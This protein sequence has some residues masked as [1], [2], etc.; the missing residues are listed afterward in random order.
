MRLDRIR[1]GAFCTSIGALN[2]LFRGSVLGD[3]RVTLSV[4]GKP[5]SVLA[6]VKL[7]PSDLDG[8][9]QSE[10]RVQQ[11][12]LT[13]PMSECRRH[14]FDMNAAVTQSARVGTVSPTLS[15]ARA[16]LRP[17]GNE[18]IVS[19]SPS[20]S[21]LRCDRHLWIDW[22]RFMADCGTQVW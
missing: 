11:A 20:L 7:I 12:Q 18:R 1:S 21:G 13:L 14:T 6:T 4:P 5:A 9:V 10:S 17:S 15:I 19:L 2:P 8:L 16:T 22:S 3:G